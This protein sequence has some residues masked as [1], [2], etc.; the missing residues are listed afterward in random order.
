MPCSS[1]CH[2][3]SPKPAYTESQLVNYVLRQP[4]RGR[5]R[6]EQRTLSTEHTWEVR[7]AGPTPWSMYRMRRLRGSTQQSRK[8]RLPTDAERLSLA[9]VRPVGLSCGERCERGHPR[10]ERVL[11]GER[12]KAKVAPSYSRPRMP[13]THCAR[14]TA[15]TRSGQT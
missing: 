13:H 7:R 11:A 8:A 15:R 2:S 14:C 4:M 5:D 3:L 1:A 12:A 6:P 10:C 9:Q